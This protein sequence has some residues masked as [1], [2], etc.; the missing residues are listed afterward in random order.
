M[1]S[2]KRLPKGACVSYGCTYT[3]PRDSVLA[4]VTAGYAD[5]VRRQLSN[6]MEVLLHGRR[7]KQV[8]RVCMDMFMVDVTDLP[9]VQPGDTATLFGE[10]GEACLPVEELSD[11][12]GTIPYEILCAPAPRV[13]RVYLD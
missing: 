13:K 5:G 9:G 3:L 6:Q 7:V 4:V 10:D 12:C 11:L 8:G 2:V 1:A